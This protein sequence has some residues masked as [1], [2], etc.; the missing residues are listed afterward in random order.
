VMLAADLIFYWVHRAQ[1]HF[2]FLWSMH[3]F[4]HSD[5]DVNVTSS[6]RHY[7]LEKPCGCLA[8]CSGSRPHSAPAILANRL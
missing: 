6:Y 3:S 1:H 2:E 5:D 7:W 8:W 4:H